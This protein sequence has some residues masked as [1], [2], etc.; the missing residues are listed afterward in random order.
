MGLLRY[1]LR[2]LLSIILTLWVVATGTFMLMHAI[3]GGPFASEKQLP[4]EIM[5]NIE[6]RYHL[7]DP[8]WK[9]YANYMTDLLQLDLGPSFKYEGRTVN[10]IIKEGFPISAQLGALA[11]AAA[12]VIGIPLGIVAAL[13]RGKAMDNLVMVL[14][15][16]G[17][18]VPS[19]IMATLLMVI[20]AVKLGWLVAAG[21]GMPQNMIMPVVCLSFLP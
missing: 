19:F 5:A 2:R 12:L 3:P 15:T 8:L 21:W 10:D 13:N 9:Q 17:Y 1:T 7:N 20:F 11:I 16:I 18:S 14:G 4:P 6:A